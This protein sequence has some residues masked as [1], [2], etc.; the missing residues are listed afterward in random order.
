MRVIGNEAGPY[1]VERFR[2]RFGV[3]VV[4]SYGSTEGGVTVTRTADQPSGALGRLPDGVLVV[5]PVSGTPRA[6]AQ[7]DDAGR[8]LNADEC[9][10]EIVNTAP[11]LFEGYYKNDEAVRERTRNGWYWSGD[12]GYVD[13]DGWLWFAGATTTGC[14]STVRTSPPTPVERV[15]SRFPGVVL[16]AIYAVPATDVGDEVMATIQLAPGVEFDPRAFDEFLARQ[17]DLGVKWSPR[18]VRIAADLPVT[19]TSKILKRRLR[20]ER[21]ECDDPIWW[22][23]ERDQ[24]LRRL[25]TDDVTS[26][27][28][29]FAARGRTHELDAR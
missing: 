27:R 19:A 13:A 12:L 29:A 21:W 11:S 8:L 15:I 18:Y 3:Q 10:G 26:I 14:A 9:V 2:E 1:D 25:T 23:P 7:F 16:A 4:D 24:A 28:H 6:R 20:A 17:P 5:D 22:R